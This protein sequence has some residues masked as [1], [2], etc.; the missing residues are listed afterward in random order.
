[1]FVVGTIRHPLLLECSAG[2]GEA[3]Q[4]GEAAD[5]LAGAL[6]NMSIQSSTG[7]AT[8]STVGR[9]PSRPVNPSSNVFELL[10]RNPSSDEVFKVLI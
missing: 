7:I 5:D 4:E 9:E 2:A 1:M 6:G 3:E 10:G 8:A